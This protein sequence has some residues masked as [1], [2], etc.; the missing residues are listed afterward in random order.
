M[1]EIGQRLRD[2][3]DACVSSY[4][5]WAGDK[6]NVAVRERLQ[7]TVHELRKVCARLEIEVALSER[8]QMSQRPIPVPPHRS[9]KR[10]D[11]AGSDDGSDLP[12][13]ITEVNGNGGDEGR[14]SGPRQSRGGGGRSGGGARRPARRAPQGGAEG[15]E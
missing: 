12:G 9:S 7:E 13:F 6:K 2:A 1:D 11:E 4:E 5:A 10:R 15:N 3:A 8:E 14:S